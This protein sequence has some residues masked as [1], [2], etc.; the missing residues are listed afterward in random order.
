MIG[1]R[2]QREP[3]TVDVDVE[4]KF[5]LDADVVINLLLNELVILSLGD[6]TLGE[7]GARSTNL[8][9]LGEGADGGGGEQ[10]KVEL[11]LLLG[12]TLR[13]LRLAAVV[14]LG[15]LGLA[16]LDLWVVGAGRGGTSVQGLGVGLELLLDG[17][18]ALSDSLGNQGNLNSL[19]GGEGEPVSDLGVELLLGGK[20]VGSVE[21]GARGSGNDAVLAELLNG[22]LNSLNGAL[23]VGL[24]DVT[25]VNNTSREDGV[26][27]KGTDNGVELLR[28][29]DKVNVD[30]VD[31]LGDKVKVVDDVTEVGGEDELGDLVTEGGKLLSRHQPP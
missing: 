31:V 23:E 3:L 2:T 21:E 25:A 15:D 26:G 24:P 1:G 11:L 4:A 19:L 14:L 27:A 18:R 29:A 9:G 12:D 13:E 7:L 8:L 30:S 5:L 22:R 17:G 16:V 10:R 6:L 20:G 28:V